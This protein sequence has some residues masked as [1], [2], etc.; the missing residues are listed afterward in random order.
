MYVYVYAQV[1]HSK[2][3]IHVILCIQC[4]RSVYSVHLNLTHEYGHCS[5]KIIK[6]IMQFA[7]SIGTL[8]SIFNLATKSADTLTFRHFEQCKISIKSKSWTANLKVES[9]HCF[10]MIASV[11]LIEFPTTIEIFHI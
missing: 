1:L 10:G 7:R 9:K 3:A 4:V 2:Q 8:Q 6:I 11:V 5:L